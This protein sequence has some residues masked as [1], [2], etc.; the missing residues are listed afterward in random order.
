MKSYRD[1]CEDLALYHEDMAQYWAQECES[2][3][4]FGNHEKASAASEMY[5]WHLSC[6]STHRRAANSGGTFTGNLEG[7]WGGVDYGTNL[8]PVP[9]FVVSPEDASDI[10]L[11]DKLANLNPA[12]DPE[13]HRDWPYNPY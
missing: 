13:E 12:P 8:P 10:E 11:G 6:S 2:Y 3:C 7:A 1:T 4:R 5:E 9:V